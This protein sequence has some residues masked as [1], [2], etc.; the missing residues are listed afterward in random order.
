MNSTPSQP[1][2]KILLVEDNFPAREL[3]STILGGVGYMVCTAA[4]GAEAL[5]KLR[6]PERPDLILLDLLMPVMDGWKFL[7]ELKRD[8][9]LASIPVLILSGAD[10]SLQQEGTAEA[11]CFL[12]KPVQTLEL[13]QAVQQFCGQNKG[14]VPPLEPAASAERS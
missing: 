2:K 8:P 6:S 9:A 1:N 3:M 12:H 5:E 14:Q 13:L 4:N 11:A 10:K 7:A